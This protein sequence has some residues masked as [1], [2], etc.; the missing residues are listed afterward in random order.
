M[1]PVDLPRPE[2]ERRVP[3]VDLS[4]RCLST[5]LRSPDDGRTV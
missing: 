2:S 5:R 1:P 3:C 4:S